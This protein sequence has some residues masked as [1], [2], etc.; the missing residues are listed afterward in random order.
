MAFE[1][2][3]F[4]LAV[5]VLLH[6]IFFIFPLFN[7]QPEMNMRSA[8]V[9]N[10]KKT[11]QLFLKIRSERNGEDINLA[12]LNPIGRPNS[13]SSKSSMSSPNLNNFSLPSASRF[14]SGEKKSTP[15]NNIMLQKIKGKDIEVTQG[16][17]FS[18]KSKHAFAGS[19]FDVGIVLPEGVDEDELNRFEEMFY[20]FRKR[21]AEQYINQI[22]LHATSVE[23]RYPRTA[24]P[25]T[26]KI[27]LLK[28]KLTYDSQGN[29]QRISFL[30]KSDGKILQEY[31]QEVMNNMNKIPNPPHAILNSE[32]NFELVFGLNI[33]D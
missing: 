18:E 1:I 20:S 12:T 19:M 23:N 27:Q 7:S 32:E 13:S 33:I 26:N 22:V 29:L 31:Y 14:G 3:A 2:K 5:S 4:A 16:V 28:A 6:I 17:R 21:V 15:S 25:W 11:S 9:K 30:Q 24:F 8:G 10:G